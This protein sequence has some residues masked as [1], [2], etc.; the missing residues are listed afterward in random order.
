[1]LG[2]GSMAGQQALSK[3]QQ[4]SDFKCRMPHPSNCQESDGISSAFRASKKL[5]GNEIASTAVSFL[6]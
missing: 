1:M 2:M 5:R 6:A 4:A 3:G